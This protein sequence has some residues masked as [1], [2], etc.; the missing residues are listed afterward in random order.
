M[1]F[2]W[3][4]ILRQVMSLLV[5]FVFGL[6]TLEKLIILWK[7]GF[8]DVSISKCMRKMKNKYKNKNKMLQ[9]SRDMR[10]R[11]EFFFFLYTKPLIISQVKNVFVFWKLVFEKLFFKFFCVCLP[12]KKLINRKYFPVNEK[13]FS[14]KG[15]FDLIYRKVFSFYFGRKTL[16]GSCEKFRNVILFVD[17]IKFDPQTFNC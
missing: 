6:S 5:N 12:F 7:E 4:L 14:V 17:Y 15:K 1:S 9:S 2:S 13:Y 8:F 10:W 3:V 16:S 11:R